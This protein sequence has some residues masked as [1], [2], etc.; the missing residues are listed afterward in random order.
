MQHHALIFPNIR[1]LCA[2]QCVWKVGERRA[3]CGERWKGGLMTAVS[4]DKNT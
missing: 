4:E 2:N 3:G 1:D